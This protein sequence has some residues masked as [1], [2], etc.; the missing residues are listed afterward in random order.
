M[1]AALVCVLCG[2][3]G[4]LQPLVCVLCGLT[5][6]VAMM[7]LAALAVLLQAVATGTIHGTVVEARTGQPLAAVLVRVEATGQQAISD[8]EGRFEIADVPAAP[9]T[10]LVSVVGYGLARREVIVRA[11]ETSEVTLA[12]AEGA[13]TYVE[14]VVVGA[15]AFRDAEP[16][17]SAQSTL[18]S[19]DLLALRG[20]VA[21]D[22]FRAIQA[23]PEV[24]TGDDFRAEFAVRGLGPEH[25]GIAIDGVDTPLLFHTV[26]GVNDAGSLALINTDVLE[27]AT[28]LAGAYP[29][30]AGA[31]LGARLDFTTRDGARDWVRGRTLIGVSAVTGVFEGPLGPTTSEA[32]GGAPAGARGSWLVALRKS[33]LGWLLRK[34]D[35]DIEGAFGFT[36]GQGTL[37]W[38]LTPAQS[39]RVTVVAGRSTWNENDPVPD[40]NTLDRATNRSVLTNLQWRYAASP[41]I[42]LRQQAY[43]V[44]AEVSEHRNGG[45][46]ARRRW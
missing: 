3:F 17:V 25:T 28:L 24:A 2:L 14:S 46:S 21:D 33:Y 16:G 19:R 29:Q 27:S 39:V 26:R 6:S 37:A 15:P 40:P 12:I 11:G 9:H 41:R 44:D 42:V 34:L 36:D 45:S 4:G 31:H 23:L 38:D 32:D 35:S 22:P 8:E 10:L 30:R 7:V 13:S 20:V 18:G 1:S 43:L 5:Q